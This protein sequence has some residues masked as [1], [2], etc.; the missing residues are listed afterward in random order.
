MT[1]C[2]SAWVQGD[3]SSQKPVLMV[4]WCT[5][6]SAWRCCSKSGLPMTK[7]PSA[8]PSAGAMTCAADRH[9]RAPAALIAQREWRAGAVAS[10]SPGWQVVDGRRGRAA[11]AA[12]GLTAGGCRDKSWSRGR[13]QTV[14]DWRR[15]SGSGQRAPLARRRRHGRFSA[16]L[17]PGWSAIGT[18]VG[19]RRRGRGRP[20]VARGCGARVGA[21]SCAGGAVGCS[22]GCAFH[23]SHRRRTVSSGWWSVGGGGG[24]WRG[25]GG[26]GV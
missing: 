24:R 9:A 20:A 1:S 13:W 6:S 7:L 15:C 19:G 12:L 2:H 22:A 5:V 14:G 4:T 16:P 18:G 11:R 26:G 21:G 8:A 25:V 17:R 10:G 3:S 23:A